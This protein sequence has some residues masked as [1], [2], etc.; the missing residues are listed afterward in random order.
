MFLLIH[1]PCVVRAGFDAQAATTANL[2][3]DPGN[4]RLGSKT[5]FGKEPKHLG[6]GA[7]GLGNRIR[8]VLRS[9]ARTRQ[10]DARR[11][12]FHRTQFH[13]SLCKKLVLVVPD[14]KCS[15]HLLQTRSGNNCTSQ[16]HQVRVNLHLCPGQCISSANNHFL[17]PRVNLRDATAKINGAFLSHRLLDKLF[18]FLP[19]CT[20]IHIEHIRLAVMYAM[21]D[22]SRVFGRV[23]TAY[24]RTVRNPLRIVSRP[25]TLYEHNLLRRFPVRRSENRTSRR[26]RCRQ[27]PFQLQS[28]NHVRVL[29]VTVLTVNLPAQKFVPRR[30]HY[31]ANLLRHNF[32]RLVEHHRLRLANL[33][34]NLALARK[35][36]PAVLLVN[37]CNIGNRLRKRYV[38][39]LASR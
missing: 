26:P 19:A 20:N 30:N 31:S 37:R 11:I 38:N 6:C 4:D 23:H 2:L 15:G 32:I 3:I 39:R 17:A 28:V 29:A 35:I 36:I 33:L 22:Q 9:L 21:F 13:V 1:R 25:N 8:N 10:K 27:H 18:I 24:L 12:C 16:H 34:T 7:A 5:V 14:A